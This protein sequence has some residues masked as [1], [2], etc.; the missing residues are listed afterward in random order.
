MLAGTD[1]RGA[2]DGA[3]LTR[4]Y[5]YEEIG[6]VSRGVHLS[7]DALGRLA[8][9]QED[10]YIVLNDNLWIARSG[11]ELSGIGMHAARVD[12][13]GT[14][15]YGALGSWGIL[16]PG[17]GGRLLPQSL[18]PAVFPKWVLST[19]FDKLLCR[20]EG[21][22]FAGWNG[23]VF[24][25][26]L[27]GVHRF[28]EVPGVSCVFFSEGTVYVSSHD[29]GVLSLDASRQTLT[30]VDP[31]VFG[32]RAIGQFADAGPNSGVLATT[33]RQL[34]LYRG[35]ELQPVPPPLGPQLAGGVTALQSLPEGGVAV[36]ITGAGV[37]VVDA[38]GQVRLSL[39]G[40]EYARVTA[41]ASRE[42]G[43]LWAA[44]ETG[45]LKI[46]HSQPFTRFG[47][48]LG[49]PIGW[50]QVVSWQGGIVIASSGRLYTPIAAR[51]D[52]PVH[53]EPMRDQPEAGTWAIAVVGTSLLAGNKSGV[54]VHQPNKGF[55]LAAPGV[56]SARLVPVDDTT[57]IAID[58]DEISAVQYRDGRW[59]ECAP[60]IPGVGY[61]AIV[62]A[63]RNSAWIEVGVNRVARIGLNGGRLESRTFEQF[64]WKTPKW[65][66]VSV[67][68]STVVLAGSENKRIFFDEERQAI[69]AAP[70]LEE[71]LNGAPYPIIRICRDDTG[72]F[73]GSHQHGLFSLTLNDGRPVYDSAS[74]GVIEERIPLV[75]ALPG[76]DIW[77]STGQ[78]LYHL[79]RDRI[80]QTPSRFQPVLVGVRDSRSN[81]EILQGAPLPATLRRL[82]HEENNVAFEFFAGSYA[83]MRPPGYE[84]RLND[85]PWQ[86]LATGSTIA[87]SNLREGR[88]RLAVRVVDGRGAISLPRDFAFEVS[89]PWFR[90]WFALA[91][92][93]LLVGGLLFGVLQFSMRRAKAR[94]AE[95]ED[96]VAERTHELQS[97]MRRLQQETRTSATLAERN[98]LAGEIHDSLE[99]GFTGLTLQLETTASF[100][101]CPP[102]VKSGLTVALNMVSYSRNEVRHAV[103]DMHSPILASTDLETA[104]KRILAQVA[105]HPDYAKLKI[106]GTPRRLGS[107][108]EHHLLRIAQEAIT[109]AVKHAAAQHVEVVLAFHEAAVELTIRDDGRGFEPDA[110]LHGISC[111]FGLPSFRGRAS[112]MGGTVAIDSRPGAGTRITVCVPLEHDPII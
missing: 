78:S 42:P 58:A 108:I 17:P 1:A 46:L 32:N 40:P 61:P 83:S 9:V 70:E 71:L 109:N 16:A 90:R 84:Y 43:V 15:L 95:L 31:R 5:P 12:L 66:N 35:G 10:E 104:V 86:K 87:F 52:G 3:P 103:R 102:E 110:V 107:T 53:F 73:W 89:P 25:D 37:Y 8:V 41:L 27:S 72:T 82:R 30:T 88:Y 99:Q 106:E 36:A 49:L 112:K 101:A 98:R 111:H 6:R 93:P 38:D 59:S 20:P 94:N 47:Q 28:F 24:R 18:V 13:D 23:V 51:G 39:T 63:G 45:V 2:I 33:F 57:C 69:S 26:R 92:Y 77:I 34:L 11:E 75:R 44:N 91:S 80:P 19:N 100:P 14:S 22:Y 48:T 7:F 62:H 50:P 21:V 76:G 97:T 64:P 60:R 65:V 67:L 56:P 29:R 81:M 85:R 105:P 55:T 68:G 74:Y 96:L 79:N 54:Y 4:F